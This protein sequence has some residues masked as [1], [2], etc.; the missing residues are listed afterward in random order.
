MVERAIY[1]IKSSADIP[2]VLNDLKIKPE[3]RKEFLQLMLSATNC[4]LNGQQGVF[5]EQF[6]EY[7]QSTFN[8]K[9]LIKMLK[10]IDRSIM[11]IE[12][13][14]NF[15]YVIDQLFYTILKEKYLCK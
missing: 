13:N 15:N 1:G 6:I 10:L 11:M 9:V 2:H 4:A 7:M 14:V 3:Q 8:I 12:S 5:S